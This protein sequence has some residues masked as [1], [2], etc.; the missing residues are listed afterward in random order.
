MTAIV[1]AVF[2]AGVLLVAS[3]WL[4]PRT[5]GIRGIVE[6]FGPI[7]ALRET[8]Q[9]AGLPDRFW[10]PFL[11]VSVLGAV[12]AAGAAH[13]ACQVMPLTCTVGIAGLLAP[14]AMLRSRAVARRR[15]QRTLWPDVVDHL[16]SGVRS[17]LALPDSVAT[18]ASVGPIVLRPAFAAFVVE[19]RTTGNFASS[20]DSLKHALA[21]PVADR[22]IETLRMARDVGGTDLPAVLQ[23]LAAHLR[24]DAAVRAEAEARQ[25]WVRNA[26]RLGVASPWIILFLLASRPETAEAYNSQ[27]GVVLIVSGAVVSVLAYRIMLRVGRLDTERRWFR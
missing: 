19:S 10:A 22:I 14:I 27:P 2:A 12:L 13:G 5:T 3:H 11:A 20:L 21:D 25:S 26:A 17:G 24:D 6:R 16:V 23:A 15:M 1:S 18:L 9:L 8:M 7:A 4:W